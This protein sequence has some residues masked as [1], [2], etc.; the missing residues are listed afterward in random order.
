MQYERKTAKILPPVH[1]PP[2]FKR[3][4]HEMLIASLC[5]FHAEDSLLEEKRIGAIHY[6]G[7]TELISHSLFYLFSCELRL[8]A[9]S[10][11]SFAALPLAVV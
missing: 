10:Y 2:P 11:F 7:F 3:C 9:V 5:A 6:Y 1:I 8:L 4:R